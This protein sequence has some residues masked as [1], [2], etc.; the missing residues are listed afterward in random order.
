MSSIFS[1]FKRVESHGFPHPKGPTSAFIPSASIIAANEAVKKASKTE[2]AARRTHLKLTDEQKAEIAQYALENGNCSA[3]RHFSEKLEVPLKESS[4]R[5]WVGKCKF[6]PEKKVKAKETDLRV[7]S[8]PSAKRGRPLLLGEELD[9]Q[10]QEY[11]RALRNEGGV[12]TIPVT[13]AVG[14]AIVE[15]NNR[16]LLSKHGGSIEITNNWAR[17]L[18]HH[19]SFVKRR[20]GSTRKIAVANFD[21]IKEQFLLDIQ[22]V[23]MMEEIPFDLILNWDQTGIH[24]VPGSAWTM[25]EKGC[26]RV[27]IAGMDDK[28]QITAVIC[29]SMTG[30]LVPFQL[31]YSGTTK[32]CLPK[33]DGIPSDWHVTC[34]SNHWSNEEKMK[35]YLELIIFPYVRQKRSELNLNLQ[36]LSTDICLFIATH[37]SLKIMYCSEQQ[38]LKTQFYFDSK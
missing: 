8:L 15:S 21:E 4:I 14:T 35:E 23:T 30:D 10:V 38:I 25:E 27:E 34:T 19:M 11:I 24:V 5:T 33:Y 7:K 28:R 36:Q 1:Y 9:K 31:I 13:M 2:R 20:E 29:G 32:A 22:A 37:Y 17:S 12:V 18:L 3:V 26:R 16:M 6:E